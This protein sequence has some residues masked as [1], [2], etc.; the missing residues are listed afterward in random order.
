MEPCTP[1]TVS[2][3]ECKHCPD[4]Q[5]ETGYDERRREAWVSMYCQHDYVPSK[6]LKKKDGEHRYR[7]VT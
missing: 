1:E 7:E 5:V 2:F 4:F 3:E 6:E